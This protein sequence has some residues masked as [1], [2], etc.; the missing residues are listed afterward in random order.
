MSFALLAALAA[1]PAA[2]AAVPDAVTLLSETFDAQTDPANFGFPTEAG[3]ADGVLNLT[4]H[5]RSYT[6]SVKSFSSAISTERTLDLSFDWK[7]AVANSGR[8][9]GIEL[10][11]NAGNLV[12]AIAASSTQL[13]YATV[14]PVSDSTA[15][16]ASLNPTWALVDFDAT[17]WYTIDLHMDFTVG[18]V[19]Y[20]IT[21][22]ASS[23]RV[24]VS[25]T[26]ATTATG[27]SRMV[28]CDYYSLGAQSIDN[29]RIQRP[30]TEAR[31]ALAG[32]TVYALGDSIVHGHR[33][34]RGF[35]D[36][37]AEREGMVLSDRAK[38]GASIG[39][40]SN[41]VITQVNYASSVAPDYV[42]FDGGTN[43]ARLMYV[44]QAYTLG[45]LSSST[46]PADF[47]T[48]TYT[49]ALENLIYTMKH[50]WPTAQI[51]FVAVHKLGDELEW[52][53][54]I[55]LREVTLE[56][57]QKWGIA[58]A[59]VHGDT[60]FDGRDDAQASAYSFDNLANGYPGSNGSGTHPNIAGITQFYVPVLTAKLAELAGS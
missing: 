24:V 42:V 10:R 27:L 35:I 43:D 38:N 51:V 54:R 34:A 45:A 30:G 26:A 12:F 4:P 7:T 13:R 20:T 28:A 58:V 49:G 14:G 18:T 8:N 22:K 53:T 3:I 48:T 1:P 39:P 55:A 17:Q 59:D 32:S 15:A 31:G 19:Q 41:Q 52:D 50:K 40:S 29:F 56:A 11:D 6:T 33:Y 16:P 57:A 9:T 25:A 36:F 60:T 47:D 21:S 5:S 23:P 2:V 37:V 46:D 44:D